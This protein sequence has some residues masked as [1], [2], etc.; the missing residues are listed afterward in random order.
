MNE[1]NNE[2]NTLIYNSKR[3]NLD[4]LRTDMVL[5][6]DVVNEWGGILLPKD[7][8]LNAVN[9]ARLISNGLKYVYVKE[10]T[11]NLDNPGLFTQYQA[12]GRVIK[13]VIEAKAF[14]EF[15]ATYVEKTEELKKS[16]MAI[17]DGDIIELD[18]LYELT[19]GVMS[20]LNC[21]SDIF[22][23]LSF[24]KTT[25]EH[26]FSHSNNVALLCNL[27][28]NWIGLN[29]TELMHLTTAGILHDLGKTKLDLNILNKKGKLTPEEYEH[30]KQHTVIGYR[31]L[32]KQDIPLAIKYCALMHHEKEDGS[33]YPMGIKGDRINRYAKIVAICDIYDAM[34]ANRIYR[35]KICPFDVIKQF[36]QHSFGILDT[37]FLLIFLQNIAYT[38]VG[39]WVELSNGSPAEIAFVHRNNLSR[40]IVRTL[41]DEIIDLNDRKDI[42]IEKVI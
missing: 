31:M 18:K 3:L 35:G 11:I 8:M 7:T 10:N 24:I 39:S 16:L 17:S 36:E 4:E 34:T 28:G 40:P 27:F 21:R 32:E 5:A 30:V 33:G 2:G 12:A 29:Q 26:T 38:Y 14:R 37:E 9:F 19:D 15:E 13:P 20:K 42:S 23:Y 41:E 25:D 1:G 22:T 6:K